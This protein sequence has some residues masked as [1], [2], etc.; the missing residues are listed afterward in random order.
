MFKDIF[1]LY[2]WDEVKASIYSK[3]GRDVELA[4]YKNKRDLEDFKALISPGALPYLEQMS[5]LSHRLTLNRFGRTM[6]M[7]IPLY[8]SNECQNICTYCGFSFHNH[9]ARI[10][11]NDEEI[12]KEIKTVKSLG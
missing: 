1:E 6:Q 9:I 12:L 2:N 4:L 10:T 8:L 5:Q 3:T 11:L 7:Y